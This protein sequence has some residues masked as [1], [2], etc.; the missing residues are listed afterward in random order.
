MKVTP[1]DAYKS[2][3]GIKNHFTQKKYDYIKYCGKSRASLQ[4]FYKRKDRMWFEKLSRQ[5]SD[6]E[7]IDFFV[8]NFITSTDPSTMW[9]GEIIKSGDRNYTEW[10]K[11]NQSLSYIFKE[12]MSV[13]DGE[14]FNSMIKCSK[15]KHP[16]LLKHYL[17]GSICIES[18]VI[19]NK[20]LNFSSEYDRILEDPVW[21]TLSLKL[22]KYESFINISVSKYRELLKNVIL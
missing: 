9:I 11:R 8:A 7:V 20:I 21:E 22:K 19:L 15:G 16:P 2:Y 17:N 3:L 12:E 5:K 14:D 4:S 13:F 6:D 1:F 18:M 10:Q